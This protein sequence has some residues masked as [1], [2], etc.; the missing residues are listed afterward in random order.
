MKEKI[1]DAVQ[2]VEHG[3]ENT[4]NGKSKEIKDEVKKDL[5]IAEEEI[6]DTLKTT[7]TDL[8]YKLIPL[9]TPDQQSIDMVIEKSK[10]MESKVKG[11]VE[12]SE[13]KEDSSIDDVLGDHL[14]E[15][16]RPPSPPESLGSNRTSSPEPEIEKA[17]ANNN[18]SP[19]TPIPTYSELENL[20][21]QNILQSASAEIGKEIGDVKDLVKE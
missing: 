19:P 14:N 10:E 16:P 5:T 9:K 2:G 11:F 21:K 6:A 12:T 18:S 13:A 20:S 8:G 1:S 4:F 15:V 17:L 7:E 3:I